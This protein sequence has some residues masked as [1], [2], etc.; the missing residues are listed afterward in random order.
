[1][2][3]RFKFPGRTGNF[4]S[5]A[6]PH[7]D[8]INNSP[9][10]WASLTL[11]PTRMKRNWIPIIATTAAL[12]TGCTDQDKDAAPRHPGALPTGEDLQFEQ[13]RE[14]APTAN[15]HF[16]AGQL[17]ESQKRHA[18]ALNQYHKALD[19]DPG[20]LPTLYRLAMLNTRLG[21]HDQAIETWK[22]YIQVTD[23][24]A[25]GYSNLGYACEI[26]G[27]PADAENAYRKGIDIDPKNQPSR[28]NYGLLLARR[29]DFAAATEHLS[30]VL[31][32]AQV[33]YNLASVHE[34]QDRPAEARL[35]Y[36]RALELDPTL[37]AARSRLAGLE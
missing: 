23:D 17:A 31:T 30:A 29:G 9:L 19:R 3:L 5:C 35:E 28:V 4:S 20:H 10:V 8:T 22:R 32:P 25:T 1:M 14:P 27:R 36:R 15:T 2:I 21:R 6:T 16:A 34:L 18:E 12:L 7:S 24:P 11:D 13:S 33:H 26:A 37:T